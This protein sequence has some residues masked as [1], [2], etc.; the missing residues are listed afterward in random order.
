MPP[1]LSFQCRRCYRQPRPALPMFQ[2]QSTPVLGKD[3]SPTLS[4]MNWGTWTRLLKAKADNTWKGCPSALTQLPES[5]FHVVL[6]YQHH[7][8]RMACKLNLLPFRY[9]THFIITVGAPSMSMVRVYSWGEVCGISP[10][11]W[12][13]ISKEPRRSRIHNGAFS[14]HCFAPATLVRT[15]GVRKPSGIRLVGAFKASVSFS[16]SRSMKNVRS[17]EH[18]CSGS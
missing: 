18:P 9:Q 17:R 12:P 13:T 4:L 14:S 16:P 6:V 5:A 11:T 7:Q 3:P 10:V 15:E 2:H 1:L 8:N